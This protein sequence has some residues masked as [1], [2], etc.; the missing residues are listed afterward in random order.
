MGERGIIIYPGWSQHQITH[1]LTEETNVINLP[2]SMISDSLSIVNND[3]KMVPYYLDKVSDSKVS[4]GE[5]VKIWLKSN[6]NKPLEMIYIRDN[7]YYSEV[8]SLYYKFDDR[9]EGGISIISW[10]GMYESGNPILNIDTEF[11]RKNKMYGE[12]VQINYLLDDL[13]WRSHYTGVIDKNNMSLTLK[14][15]INNETDEIISVDSLRLAGGDI[16]KPTRSR[17]YLARSQ[18]SSMERNDNES[19]KNA[20]MEEL[21]I[22]ESDLNVI[23]KGETNIPL[24]EY[25]IPVKKIYVYDLNHSDV[26]NNKYAKKDRTTVLYRFDAPEKMVEGNIHIYAK[27]EKSEKLVYVSSSNIKRSGIDE[28]VD[29]E[30]SSSPVEINTEYSYSYESIESE[31]KTKHNESIDNRL[32][33]V[34][35]RVGITNNLNS[36]I[37]IGLQD[38]IYNIR[39]VNPTATIQKGNLYEWQFNIE[40]RQ[41]AEAFIEI[42][43]VV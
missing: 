19:Y 5:L 21:Q 10:S 39:S 16:R 42:S 3:G 40:S 22:F 15:T 20:S 17:K 33:N 11:L 41:T 35:I 28:S 18:T 43:V 30:L 1:N 36:A 9:G 27:D 6:N 12:Q 37:L 14:G 29:I 31:T 38:N 34:K 13:S 2:R 25:V 23:S 8:D 4:T 24:R 7:I 32:L 26:E